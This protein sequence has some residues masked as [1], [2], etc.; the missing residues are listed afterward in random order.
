MDDVNDAEGAA[1]QGAEDGD[2]GDGP[3]DEL[4]IEIVAH[5]G[6]AVGLA[7][8]HGEDGVGHH[9]RYDHVRAH[10]AV[11]VLLLLGFADAFRRHLKPVAQVAQ[12][13]VVARIDV[14]LLRRHFELDGVA[15]A[16]HSGAEVD[17]DDVVT[18]G[19]PSDVVGVAEGVDLQGTDVGRE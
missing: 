10:G 4:E 15:L 7:D 9:P 8:G 18:L 19:A 2:G 11:V 14:Q 16:G 3:E 1:A 17:V 5:V 6:A 13:F 12:R